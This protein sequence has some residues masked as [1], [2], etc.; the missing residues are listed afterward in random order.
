MRTV[1]HNV[2]G[3]VYHLIWRFVD[4]TWFF[5]SNAER[6][7]YLYYFG[8]AMG[9]TDWRCLSYAL[10]SNHI[11]A[12]MIAGAAPL[13][14]WAKRVH[15][16]FATWM[17]RQRGRLG[18]LIADRPKDI[19]VPDDRVPHVIAY[20]HNNPVR[21]GIADR[22]ASSMWT[23][24]L[25][26]TGRARAPAWLDV[27]EGLRR[28]GLPREAFDAWIDAT[29]GEGR[30]PSDAALRREARKRGALELATPVAGAPTSYPLVARP[31]ARVRPDPRVVIVVAARA[32]GLPLG[33][34]S[35]RR[36]C[37]AAVAGRLAA[38]HAGRALGITSADLAAALGIS[39]S[40]VC[41]IAVRRPTDAQARL[42]REVLDR[43]EVECGS[44]PNVKTVPERL[45][46]VDTLQTGTVL[47]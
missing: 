34:V 46:N 32:V 15:S 45:N 39:A 14:S 43:L 33:E 10:M 31:F 11:H 6:A 16:P 4:R 35:S 38:V 13:E 17:N 12:A 47:T 44:T 29:P 2:H 37:P 18:P 24:H 30:W 42:V 26:Y 9:E 22:A 41:Q 8:R 20:I 3:V 5:E 36:R 27:D 40:A 25:A 1:R 28:C 19:A 21:A 23:S 7:R